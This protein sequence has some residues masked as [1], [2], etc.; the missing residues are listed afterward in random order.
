V[1]VKNKVDVWN[2]DIET[3][4]KD[5]A[6]A[7]RMKNLQEQLTYVYEHSEFYKNKFIDIGATPD[8]ITTWEDFR[9]LPVFMD[10]ETE[11]AGRDESLERYGHPYGMHLCVP[12]EEILVIKTTGGTTGLPTFTY[13]F[14]ANDMARWNEGTARLFYL[15]GLRKGDRVLFCFPL[16]GCWAGSIVKNPLFQMNIAA[17]EIGAETEASRIIEFAGMTRPNVLMATPSFAETFAQEYQT[18]T[19]HDV[20]KL[21]ITKLFLTGEPGV[22][23]PA[24]KKH[25]EELYG[26]RWNEVFMVNGEAYVGSCNQEE[27]KGLHEVAPDLTIWAADLVD[28]ETRKPIPVEEGA[29]GEGVLTSLKREGTPLIKYASGDIIQIESGACSCNYT[30]SGYRVRILGRLS[31]RLL[32]NEK[33]IYPVAI[34]DVVVSY[35]PKVTGAMRIVLK[36]LPPKIEPPLLLKIEHGINI[37][38]DAL[39]DLSNKI[40]KDI[41]NRFGVPSAIEFVSPGALGRVTKKTPIFEEQY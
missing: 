19:G 6:E 10:K 38:N 18:T 17:V 7:L 3:L 1:I 16:S 34:R 2:K 40:T 20:I 36:S 41:F 32:I 28:P 30:G 14:T 33:S 29:I 5:E 26:G 23:I 39:D 24:V 15:A 37:S 4:S 25:M 22:G 8:D 21:G 12:P 13:T 9:S 35:I 11:R 31:D 27:Y